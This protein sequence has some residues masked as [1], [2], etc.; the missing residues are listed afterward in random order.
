MVKAKKIKRAALFAVALTVVVSCTAIPGIHAYLTD[1]GPTLENNFTI[2][3]DPTT[4]VVEKF[5][6]NFRRSKTLPI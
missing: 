3:L 4:T 2:A 5:P 1:V 6:T